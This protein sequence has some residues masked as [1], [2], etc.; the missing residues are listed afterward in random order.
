M[1]AHE[2]IKAIS[3]KEN[4]L[5]ITKVIS[6]CYFWKI[7]LSIKLQKNCLLLS[8]LLLFETLVSVTS[9]SVGESGESVIIVPVKGESVNSLRKSFKSTISAIFCSSISMELSSLISCFTI[10]A[11]VVKSC[12]VTGFI[13]TLFVSFLSFLSYLFLS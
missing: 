9:L 10:F 1:S 5:L 2:S 3:I 7:T 11:F 12:S 8:S 6:V 4:F 13:S